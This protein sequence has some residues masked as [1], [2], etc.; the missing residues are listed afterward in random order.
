M[1]VLISFNQSNTRIVVVYQNQRARGTLL[2]QPQ[3]DI[4]THQC[5]T[6]R[7][8][9]IHINTCMIYL[10]ILSFRTL[11]TIEYK[12]SLL[13]T[14]C[15]VSWSTLSMLQC[16]DSFFKDCCSKSRYQG[17][18]VICPA[19]QGILRKTTRH[20]EDAYQTS[21]KCME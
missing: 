11:D 7:R 15:L 4:V 18:S 19:D 13:S 2:Q 10:K 5:R 8:L 9:Y 12:Y 16:I 21:P 17:L 20:T 3:R 1:L 6:F 14:Q